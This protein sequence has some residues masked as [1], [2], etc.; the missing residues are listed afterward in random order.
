MGPAEAGAAHQQIVTNPTKVASVLILCM[1]A[2]CSSD[3]FF[4]A[5]S[6]IDSTATEIRSQSVQVV[7]T[8]SLLAF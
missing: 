8:S 4:A 2:C 1:L 5:V 6:K 3:D 7:L